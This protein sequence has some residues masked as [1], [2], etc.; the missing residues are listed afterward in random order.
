MTT[1]TVQDSGII[2]PHIL[3]TLDEAKRRLG[4]GAH[5]MRMARRAG[6]NVRYTG[7]RGYVLGRDIIEHIQQHSRDSK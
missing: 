4:W 1:L 2:E 6:L 5:A 3:Y 7:R